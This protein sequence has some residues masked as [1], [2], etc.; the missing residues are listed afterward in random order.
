MSNLS[1][2]NFK[3]WKRVEVSTDDSVIQA[4]IDAAEETIA[5]HC[6]RRFS[7]ATGPATSRT[8]KASSNDSTVVEIHDCASVTSVHD[9]GNTLAASSYQL[10][11]LNGLNPMGET[12]P[13]TRIRLIGGG[14]WSYLYDAAN[15]VVIAQWG[16]T[17]LPARY[18]EADKILTA[19][20]LDN[21]DIRNG[22]I[23]F[24]DYAGIRVRE[25]PVVSQLV[26]K[27]MRAQAFGIG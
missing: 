8:Y 3:A 9:A 13:Y 20:I 10:E 2:A 7:I 23:G 12:V 17:T 19:D 22:I 21:R 15:I 4:A 26:S 11:P 5:Q 1:V 16:W 25:N 14:V 6:G 18:F 24:T 27:L